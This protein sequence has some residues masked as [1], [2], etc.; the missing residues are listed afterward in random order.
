MKKVDKKKSTTVCE[1]KM[2]MSRAY[3]NVFVSPKNER[4]P[5]RVQNKKQ[6]KN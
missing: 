6:K 3:I 1:W 4:K 2:C 5:K